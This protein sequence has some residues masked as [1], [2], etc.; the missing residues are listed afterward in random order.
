MAEELPELLVTDAAAWRTWLEEHHGDSPGV[1]LVLHKKG[2]SVTT[3]NY[4]DALLEALCFGWIDGLT[5]RRDEGSYVQ[6]T[7]PRRRRSTWSPRNVER[8]A[9]LEAEGRMHEAGRAQVRLAQTDG[10]WPA[11]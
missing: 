8:V 11:V 9:R 7:T 3:L 4:E 6:R 10:R 2:G 1:W 5:R